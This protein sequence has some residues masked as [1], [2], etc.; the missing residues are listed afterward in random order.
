MCRARAEVGGG[1]GGMS[2][3]ASSPSPRLIS[4]ELWALVEPLIPPRRPAVRGRTGG[5]RPVGRSADGALK[6]R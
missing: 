5:K 4:D 1:C 2:L 3:S 6:M